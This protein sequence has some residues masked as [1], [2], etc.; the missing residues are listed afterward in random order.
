MRDDGKV[1]MQLHGAVRGRGASSQLAGRFEKRGARREDDG[2]GSAWDFGDAAGD[3]PLPPR[4]QT[5]VR[6]EIARSII[7]RNRSPDVGFSQSVNPYRG[8][9]HGMTFY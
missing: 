7:S 8:C 3:S 6:D 9:E 1:A 2:W 5:E 4:L